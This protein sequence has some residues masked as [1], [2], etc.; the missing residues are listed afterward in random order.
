MHRHRAA[1]RR[2]AR[3]APVHVPCV[4]R[5]LPW[6]WGWRWGWSCAVHSAGDTG[7]PSSREMGLKDVVVQRLQQ[8]L[9]RA[10]LP[11]CLHSAVSNIQRNLHVGTLATMWM[12]SH[13]KICE[14]R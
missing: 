9:L 2:G 14:C 4:A 12:G 6:R 10:T 7:S 1:P 3:A 5:R 13:R 11:S 8:Y